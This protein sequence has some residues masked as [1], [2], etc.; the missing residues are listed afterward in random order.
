VKRPCYSPHALRF[1]LTLLG[2]VQIFSLLLS[3]ERPA[4]AYIDPGSGFVLLQAA[5]STLAGAVYYFRHRLKRMLE[6]MRRSE[7]ISSPA[8]T[9][10]EAAENRP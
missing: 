7:Q 9:Q 1:F 4:Y 2:A 3:F 10:T 6:S 5:G 8:S